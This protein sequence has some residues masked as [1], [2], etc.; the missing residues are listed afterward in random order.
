[1]KKSLNA[2]SVE[3]ALNFEETFRAVSEAGFDGIELNIDAPGAPH[4][5][6]MEFTQADYDRIRS[7]SE[8]YDLPVVSISTSLSAG[9][10]G[11]PARHEDYRRLLLKQI[12]EEPIA[13]KTICLPFILKHGCS[14]KNISDEEEHP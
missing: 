9:M 10:S 14:V 2:W 7:L 4:G 3:K 8:K 5:L 6:S 12:E 1:M 11:I 13:E